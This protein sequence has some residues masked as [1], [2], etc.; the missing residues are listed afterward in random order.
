MNMLNYKKTNNTENANSNIL[1]RI[2]W[3]IKKYIFI[4]QII[5]FFRWILCIRKKNN[6]TYDTN[7]N[8]FYINT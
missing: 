2:L 8:K 3:I 6:N 4:I 1:I 7:Y 5:I